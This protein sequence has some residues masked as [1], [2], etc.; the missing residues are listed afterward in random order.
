MNWKLIFQLSM[1]G[2][3]MGIATVFVIPS[4][5]EPL[6]WLAIFVIC[7]VIISKK[8]GR[9]YFLYG[10]LLSLVNSV[11]VTSAHVILFDT[12]SV[13]HTSEIAMMA[14]FPGGLSPRMLMIL[15]FPVIG[16]ASGLV[17]GLFCYAGSLLRK[18][19]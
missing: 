8:A 13:R 16:I 19:F 12:Y 10:L 7:A 4:N 5:L 18:Y 2:L 6:F 17:Q 15:I 3:A 1:F 14:S 9:M 11:W